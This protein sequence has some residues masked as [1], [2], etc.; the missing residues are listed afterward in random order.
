MR[1]ISRTTKNV[2]RGTEYPTKNFYSNVDDELKAKLAWAVCYKQAADAIGGGVTPVRLP[3][4]EETYD[5][6]V[7]SHTQGL[8]DAATGTFNNKETAERVR[9]ND[10]AALTASA[11]QTLAERTKDRL[12]ESEHSA[13]DAS[14][15]NYGKVNLDNFQRAPLTQTNQHAATV[16]LTAGLDAGLGRMASSGKINPIIGQYGAMVAGSVAPILN[17]FGKNPITHS[18]YDPSGSYTADTHRLAI[19]LQ[20]ASLAASDGV[21]GAKDRVQALNKEL[22]ARIADTSG[23]PETNWLGNLT[24]AGTTAAQLASHQASAELAALMA[25]KNAGGNPFTASP[26]LIKKLTSSAPKSTF[27]GRAAQT[28][29]DTYSGVNRVGSSPLA[30]TGIA[31]SGVNAA[32]MAGLDLFGGGKAGAKDEQGNPRPWFDRLS[33]AGNTFGSVAVPGVAGALGQSWAARMATQNLARAAAAG[34]APGVATILMQG[35]K[36]LPGVVARSYAL[37]AHLVAKS[38]ETVGAM[39]PSEYNEQ[40]SVAAMGAELADEARGSWPI[41]RGLTA[42]PAYFAGQIDPHTYSARMANM[43]P[44]NEQN[45]AYLASQKYVAHLEQEGRDFTNKL[46]KQMPGLSAAEAVGA[47]AGLQ[48]MTARA[49]QIKAENEA[50]AAGDAASKQSKDERDKLTAEY[51]SRF[52]ERFPDPTSV[53]RLKWLADRMGPDA[54]HYLIGDSSSPESR[55][56]R[57]WVTG[58]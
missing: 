52:A 18:L 14:V 51:V 30:T 21:P 57:Y 39:I 47:S 13:V 15:G 23:G 49:V 37:P 4:L 28:A 42:I 33:A 55:Q 54:V 32:V 10:P 12:P 2:I 7:D 26:E 6:T 16:G 34:P 25:L 29:K 43:F 27:L 1:Q 17:L 53:A 44:V 50:A 56:V 36:A 48:H 58:K 8:F 19:E 22:M 31:L 5:V 11:G 46:F 41:A 35:V 40:Q 3:Q 38:G 45:K 9:Q 20:Q 24:G